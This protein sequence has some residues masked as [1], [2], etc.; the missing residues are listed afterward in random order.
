MSDESIDVERGAAVGHDLLDETAH[1]D[2]CS[3]H[4]T[5]WWCAKGRVWGGGSMACR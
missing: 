2:I 3:A 1:T 5:G 4:C